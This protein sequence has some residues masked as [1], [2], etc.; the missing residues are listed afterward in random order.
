MA[1]I[2]VCTN[3]DRTALY[4]SSVEDL[5]Q[6]MSANETDPT[7][8]RIIV[9]YLKGRGSKEFRDLTYPQDHSKYQ[10]LAR[11]QDRL[12]WQN[13]IEGRFT[14]YLVH[15]QREHLRDS[16][17]WRTA[18][19]WASGL[20]DQLLRLTH[21]QWLHRNARL[22]FRRP[23]GRTQLQHNEIVAKISKLIWTDPD[24]LLDADRKL[25][26]LDFRK[27]GRARAVTQECWI[28]EL[29]TAIE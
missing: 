15:V 8:H 24:E 21:R 18:E 25:L 22:H 20:M 6:W 11:Y 10:L 7:L 27:L 4:T 17:T 3:K 19:S 23:D 16:D 5:N 2:T 28:A 29:E 12:G 14:S 1:H 9:D 26:G 13:F